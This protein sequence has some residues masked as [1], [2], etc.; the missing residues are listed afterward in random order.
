MSDAE[1]K[2]LSTCVGGFVTLAIAVIGTLEGRRR[3]RRSRKKKKESLRDEESQQLEEFAAN[4]LE[5]MRGLIKSNSDL[6]EEMRK[7]RKDFSA[8]SDKF[9]LREREHRS[10]KEAV[11]RWVYDIMMFLMGHGLEMPYPSGADAEI[12][13]DVIPMAMQASRPRIKKQGT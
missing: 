1:L 8:L 7:V 9:D 10:F 3:F 13:R 2:L 4:P 5:F 6:Q 11:A 12:L